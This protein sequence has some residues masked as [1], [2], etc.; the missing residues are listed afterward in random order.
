MTKGTVIVIRAVLCDFSTVTHEMKLAFH[1][2]FSILEKEVATH[3]HF[4]I[5]ILI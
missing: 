5:V 2:I 3:E 1:G 4:T